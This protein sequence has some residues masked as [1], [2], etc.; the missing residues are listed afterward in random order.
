MQVK[1]KD[2]VV[3]GHC[4]ATGW[5]APEM[6]EKSMYSPIKADRSSGQLVQK[7]ENNFKF[8]SIF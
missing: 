7:I 6:E 3:D 1:D 4:G 8:F 2:E 5:M